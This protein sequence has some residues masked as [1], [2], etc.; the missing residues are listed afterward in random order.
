MR[1]KQWAV[2]S[3]AIA[4]LTAPAN[5]SQISANAPGHK[6]TPSKAA[7]A[8]TLAQKID[9][10]VRAPIA[11]SVTGTIMSPTNTARV[12]IAIANG[13]KSV[14]LIDA[15]TRTVTGLWTITASSKAED[16]ARISTAVL[17]G[18]GLK[19]LAGRATKSLKNKTGGKK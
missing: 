16:I 11:Q 18:M 17:E 13:E 10:L 2:L 15:P 4:A 9:G 1:M 5:A 14:M 12:S 19:P 6:W 8:E 7:P 3:L